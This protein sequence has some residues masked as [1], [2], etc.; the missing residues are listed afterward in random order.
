MSRKK[1]VKRVIKSKRT[2][3]TGPKGGTY[4]ITD[5][6]NKVYVTKTGLKYS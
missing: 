3:Q 1:I 2:L 6:G 5:K 4:Y